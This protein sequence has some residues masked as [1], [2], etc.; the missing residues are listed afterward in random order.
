MPSFFFCL[1]SHDEDENHDNM[2]H[3]VTKQQR[4]PP[5]ITNAFC[6]TK[7]L[8]FI[9]EQ[10]RKAYFGSFLTK[11]G[12]HSGR[13]TQQTPPT[14]VMY[15]NS[16]DL[17]SVRGSHPAQDSIPTSVFPPSSPRSRHSTWL[18]QQSSHPGISSRLQQQLPRLGNNQFVF[19]SSG[20]ENILGLS[21]F[22]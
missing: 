20:S 15:T 2:D 7:T 11:Y 10:N 8:F 19:W 9:E 22:E 5:E 4:D 3:R 14:P 17:R 6:R 12:R 16:C 1:S 18:V 13:P 21:D